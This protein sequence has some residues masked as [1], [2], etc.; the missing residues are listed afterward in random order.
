MLTSTKKCILNS[1]ESDYWNIIKNDVV[2][3]TKMVI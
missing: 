1:I 2:K 3:C